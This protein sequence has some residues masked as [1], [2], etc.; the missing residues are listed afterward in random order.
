MERIKSWIEKSQELE[1][2]KIEEVKELYLKANNASDEQ[3][4]KLY[5]D[6]II[7]GTLYVVFNYIER[8]DLKI[9]ESSQYGIDD[10]QSAF[11]ETWIKKIY[12]GDLFNADKYSNIFTQTFFSEVYSNLVG[13]EMVISEQF[14]ITS[15]HL[16]DLFYL[17]IKLKNSGKQFNFDDLMEAFNQDKRY[18][19]HRICYSSEDSAIMKLLE[20]MYDNLSFDKT[21][22][23][24]I[25]RTMIANYIKL[26]VNNGICEKITND[27]VAE[28]VYDDI[29]DDVIFEHF[30]ENVD[31]VLD[32]DRKRK[33]IHQRYGIDDGRPKTYEEIGKIYNISRER[34]RQIEAR[35]LRKLRYFNKIKKYNK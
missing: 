32:D 13:S 12:N 29:L 20:G 16:I 5:L 27:F 7:M 31:D 21:D 34:V 2:L 25:T 11:I 8:N 18:Y 6:K 35:S 10:I 22:D 28:D 4:K 3:L 9:F 23:L 14:K 33:V 26:F 1:R 19:Y 30:I 15:E 24:N 17:F